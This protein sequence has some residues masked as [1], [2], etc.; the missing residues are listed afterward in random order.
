MGRVLSLL[1]VCL[2]V[3][4]TTFSHKEATYDNGEM[5]YKWETKVST[6]IGDKEATFFVDTTSLSGQLQGMGIDKEFRDIALRAIDK[7]P[8]LATAIIAAF[9]PGGQLEGAL[10]EL[11]TTDPE[12]AKAIT[13]AIK[14]GW[15]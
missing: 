7:S 15:D 1:L 9:R 11:M 5:S 10:A 3:G 14:N 13:E 8:E 4:C 12:L 6:F 2:I